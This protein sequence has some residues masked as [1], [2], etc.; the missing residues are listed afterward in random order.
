MG[1]KITAMMVII[2]RVYCDDEALSIVRLHPD[3]AW[4]REYGIETVK[5]VMVSN[6]ITRAPR[7]KAHPFFPVRINQPVTIRASAA[8]IE[9]RSPLIPGFVRIS[10][11]RNIHMTRTTVKTR[12]MIQV[13]EL[14]LL[15]CSLS[16][17]AA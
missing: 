15:L 9:D 10:V 6:T 14:I 13:V 7:T 2:L 8:N 12:V 4:R 11:E 5:T 17:R 3:S 16:L 1:T